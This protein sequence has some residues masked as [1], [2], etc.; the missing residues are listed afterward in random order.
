M[1]LSEP[2]ERGGG[3]NKEQR[4]R[5]PL[6]KKAGSLSPRRRSRPDETELIQVEA[7]LLPERVSLD[8]GTKRETC[9]LPSLTYL[10]QYSMSLRTEPVL[11]C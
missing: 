1:D 6:R 3:A 4:R 9:D 7:E 8:S 5:S 2:G 10:C 11:A